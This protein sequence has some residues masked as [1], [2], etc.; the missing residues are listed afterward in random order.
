MGEGRDW[1]TVEYRFDLSHD[2]ATDVVWVRLEVERGGV[3][4]SRAARDAFLE[5]DR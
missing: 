3:I 4:R 2:D 5:E 1:P